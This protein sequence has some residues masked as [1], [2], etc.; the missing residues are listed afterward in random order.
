[1]IRIGIKWERWVLKVKQ[2]RWMFLLAFLC[3]VGIVNII[4]SRTWANNSLLNRHSLG[5]LSFE[6]ISYE[7][8]FVKILFLRIRTLIFLW[9]LEKLISKKVTA[10]GFGCFISIMTGGILTMLILANGVW[11][12]FFLLSALLPHGIFYVL[13][14]LLWCN[15]GLTYTVEGSRKERWLVSL[16]ILLLI[17]IGSICEA[18]V[19]PFLV[20]N[21]IYF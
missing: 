18:Y 8:Y 7:E 10:L 15:T 5:M 14:Y 2:K 16:L 3:G 13:A 4:G 17:V 20:K 19:C 21:V 11:G 12:I 6:E 1:M 9:I